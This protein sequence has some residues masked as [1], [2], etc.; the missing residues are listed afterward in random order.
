MWI[1]RHIELSMRAGG[2]K[3]RTIATPRSAFARTCFASLIAAKGVSAQSFT[4]PPD[5][6]DLVSQFVVDEMSG[7]VL[8][9]PANSSFADTPP[10]DDSAFL[11]DLVV[12]ETTGEV[13]NAPANSN[14]GGQPPQDGSFIIAYSHVDETTGEVSGAAPFFPVPE[15]NRLALLASG[16]LLLGVLSRRLR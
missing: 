15:P 16:V 11:S 7:E 4:P 9:A 2:T 3:M 6:S 12:D 1:R 5:E 13:L 14:F 10:N 8:S